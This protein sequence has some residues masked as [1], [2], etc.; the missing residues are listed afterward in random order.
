MGNIK[1]ISIKN[2]THYFFNDVINIKSFDSR[3]LKIDKS[4][5]K[6]LIDIYYVAYITT[7]NFDYVKI[8][9]VNP[10]YLII[11]EGDGYI[12]GKNVTKY[13]IFAFIVKKKKY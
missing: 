7:K 9:S 1:Q 6:T 8:S 12:E 10:L 4:H 2:R 11:G 3:L 5:A 13:L